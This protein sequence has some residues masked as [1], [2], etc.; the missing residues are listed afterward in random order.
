MNLPSHLYTNYIARRKIDHERLSK[1]LD[2]TTNLNA[3]TEFQ[4]LGHQIRGSAASFGFDDLVAIAERLESVNQE[5][6]S[7]LGQTALNEFYD[8]I[9]KTEKKFECT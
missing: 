4:H 8:W 6:I 7:T 1:V 3:L 5:N 2:T 9:K